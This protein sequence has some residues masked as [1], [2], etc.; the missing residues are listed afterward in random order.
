MRVERI[1]GVL[2][3]VV[4]GW[5]VLNVFVTVW[6]VLKFLVLLAIHGQG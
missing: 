3:W 1:C 5:A 2:L 4:G 6:L